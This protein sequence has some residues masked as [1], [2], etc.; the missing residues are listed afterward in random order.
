MGRKSN[1]QIVLSVSPSSSVRRDI[2]QLTEPRKRPVIKRLICEESRPLGGDKSQSHS[3]C[4][5]RGGGQRGGG[6]DIIYQGP[7]TTL[8]VN[9]Y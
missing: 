8:A 2:S 1:L 9:T 5:D 7:S 6:R 3:V 4:Q